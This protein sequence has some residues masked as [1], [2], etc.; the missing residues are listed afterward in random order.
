[1][2]QAVFVSR[3]VQ[4]GFWILS[5]SSVYHVN[6]ASTNQ[7]QL[8][9]CAP[10]VLVA[11]PRTPKDQKLHLTALYP[12]RLVSHTMPPLVNAWTV[13]DTITRMRPA[14]TSVNPVLSALRQWGMGQT[15]THNVKR[16]AL[17]ATLVTLQISLNVCGVR[18]EHTGIPRMT[19]RPALLAN[20]P[21]KAP[22]P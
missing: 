15:A 11:T 8:R 21:W 1:M 5:R 12:V 9:Q 6:M 4:A 19:V 16:T 10:S 7:V 17:L 14:R 13:H 3:V 22:L 18:V 20:I 2:I